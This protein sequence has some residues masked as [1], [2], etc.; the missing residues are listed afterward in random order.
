MHVRHGDKKA[1][2]SETPDEQYWARAQQVYAA[3][4]HLQKRIFLH[5]YDPNTVIF[6][7]NATKAAEWTLQVSAMLPECLT[8]CDLSIF[9]ASCHNIIHHVAP[10]Q[11]TCSTSPAVHQHHQAGQ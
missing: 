5:T 8:S 7:E 2:T 11:L 9:A 1:E 3:D 6:F 10:H 4:T